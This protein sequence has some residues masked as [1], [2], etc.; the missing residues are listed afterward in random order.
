[1][2]KFSSVFFYIKN[3]EI[4]RNINVEFKSNHIYG[5]V[6]EMGSGK[7]TL[8][9][10]IIGVYN[11]TTGS[12]IFSDNKRNFCYLDKQIAL[13]GDLTVIENLRFWA[14]VYKIN[15]TKKMEMMKELKIDKIYNKNVNMLSEG[16]KQLVALACTMMSE[17]ELIL[18]D[19][20]FNYLDNYTKEI[21]VNILLGEKKG[22]TIV[23]VSHDIDSLFKLS[24]DFILLNNS[25]ISKSFSTAEM[26][27]NEKKYIIDFLKKE[28]VK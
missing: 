18:L 11:P 6:G 9:K 7:S 15:L 4:L 27:E 8:L 25:T 12:I 22:R 21:I 16:N 2:I 14:S 17:A 1:M 19:E 26:S 5:I 13:Y 23:L 10:L 24:T 28:G 20:P 3:K